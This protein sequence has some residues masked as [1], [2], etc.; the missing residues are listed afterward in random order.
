MTIVYF[1]HTIKK[2]ADNECE[3][4]HDPGI[5]IK[6]DELIKTIVSSVR[7]YGIPNYIITSPYER[8]RHTAE[9]FRDI[10]DQLYDVR[11]PIF[12]DCNISEYLG[13]Q[14]KFNPQLSV[15][16]ETK[17]FDVPDPNETIDELHE[18]INYHLDMFKDINMNVWIV[19][20][21]KIMEIIYKKYINKRKSFQYLESFKIK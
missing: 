2:Y 9:L 18:R 7:K 15:S 19:T 12:V 14:Y 20:H 21:G 1:R 11:V 4:Y 16:D 13:Y 5:I 17:K 6:E 3:P 10:I 8:T